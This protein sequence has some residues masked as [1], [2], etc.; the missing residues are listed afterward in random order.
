M[1][2]VEATFLFGWKYGLKASFKLQP[3]IQ[4]KIFCQLTD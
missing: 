3:G 2:M 1:D 4:I